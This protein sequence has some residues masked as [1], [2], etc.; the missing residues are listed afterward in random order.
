MI[1]EIQIVRNIDEYIN[2]IILKKDFL[3]IIK[4]ELYDF[5]DNKILLINDII[6][7]PVLTELYDS[8]STIEDIIEVKNILDG[9]VNKSF[10]FS[11]GIP[12]IEEDCFLDYLRDR[13]KSY[14]SNKIWDCDCN[15]IFESLEKYRTINPSTVSDILKQNLFNMFSSS[16]CVNEN[17]KMI[18]E[19]NNFLFPCKN[20]DDEIAFWN[21]VMKIIDCCR[22]DEMID[23]NVRFNNGE[24]R[25][26][27]II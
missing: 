13:V 16:V 27:M 12:Q 18:F 7:Y 9:K 17:N 3:K 20:V 4:D 11:F 1:N 19:R 21:K 10:Y 23:I 5:L 22:G 25:F 14:L 26:D 2:G 8:D 24:R 15:A 6:L